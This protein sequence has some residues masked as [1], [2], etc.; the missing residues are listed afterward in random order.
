MSTDE[1]KALLGTPHE[2]YKQGEEESWYYWIDSFDAGWFGVR[3]GPDGRV[4]SK[5]GN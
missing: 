3:F 4:L 2:R 5:Y 1:V